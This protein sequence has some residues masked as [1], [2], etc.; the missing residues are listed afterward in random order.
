MTTQDAGRGEAI[1]IEPR[2]IE[3]RFSALSVRVPKEIDACTGIV[4]NGHRIRSFAYSTDVAIIHNTN[5]DAILAVYPFTGHPMITQ[6]ICSVAKAPVFVGVGGGTTQGV[7]SAELAMFSEMQ[8]VCGVVV[9]APAPIETIEAIVAMVDIPVMA[10]IVTF[11]EAAHEK[12]AAGARIINVAAGRDTAKVVAAVREAYPDLPIV[13]TGGPT[14]KSITAT[15][16]AGANAISWTP[17]DAQFLQ[18]VMMD[19]YRAGGKGHAAEAR[20]KEEVATAGGVHVASRFEKAMRDALGGTAPAPEAAPV[21]AS[22]PAPEAAGTA[23]ADAPAAAPSAPVAPADAAPA[24]GEAPAAAPA[25]ASQAG[26]G[27]DR[28]GEQAYDQNEIATGAIFDA[29]CAADRVVEEHVASADEADRELI[30]ERIEEAREVVQEEIE[31]A[32]GAARRAFRDRR[33]RY[34]TI[35]ED[36]HD[37]RNAAR[38]L[39]RRGIDEAAAR[40]AASVEASAAAGTP[41][42]FGETAPKAVPGAPK[43]ATSST[44]TPAVTGEATAPA[45]T[46]DEREGAR[47]DDGE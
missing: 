28:D 41:V 43:A 9:N 2:P 3:G 18:G 44:A 15:I 16:A 25:A 20:A 5:A 46:G 11:D 7:R 22:V 6:A 30:A 42:T 23:D 29:T 8:G 17:P 27:T 12:I 39:I 1:M 35:M 36:I 26:D 10:T 32:R 14:G 37:A 24:G 38:R 34:S 45:V 13:A 40:A 31:E 19:D 4:V 33:E 21:P 47:S